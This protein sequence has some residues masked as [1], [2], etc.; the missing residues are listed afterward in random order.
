[1]IVQDVI[2]VYTAEGNYISNSMVKKSSDNLGCTFK[3]ICR[4]GNTAF[5]REVFIATSTTEDDVTQRTVTEHIEVL[6]A[7]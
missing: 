7:E 1:M 3:W 2:D 5:R 4:M 6:P